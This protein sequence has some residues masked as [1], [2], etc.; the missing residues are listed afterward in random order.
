[1]KI[2]TKAVVRNNSYALS[3]VLPLPINHNRKIFKEEVF[4]A[5]D[6][7]FSITKILSNVCF[8][9]PDMIN[10]QGASSM[11]LKCFESMSDL[12]NHLIYIIFQHHRETHVKD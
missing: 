7:F 10:S 5:K 6:P 4:G 2:A 11:T 1:M 8:Y 9:H 3:S 12:K